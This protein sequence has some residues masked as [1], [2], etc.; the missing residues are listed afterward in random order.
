[1]PAGDRR[2]DQGQRHAR[3]VDETER[4]QLDTAGQE[5]RYYLLWI[6]ARCPRASKVTI[7][8]L[9]RCFS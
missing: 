7:S 5:F 9:Q 1:M 8:E 4:I 3:R 2:L 6:I